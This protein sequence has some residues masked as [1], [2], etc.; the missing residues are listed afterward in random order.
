MDCKAVHESLIDYI[1]GYLEKDETIIIKEHLDTCTA[2]SMELIELK[3]TIDYIAE[4][5]NKI[6]TD[7]DI[8]LNTRINRSFKRVTRTGLIAVVLS[9][10][11]V[12]T[13][14]ATDMFGF[15]ENWK[16]SSER[17]INAW[18]QLID[19]G[20]GQK[21]DISTIDKDIKITAEGVISDEINTIILLKIEDLNGNERYVPDI[22]DEDE[23]DS[24]SLGGDILDL[25]HFIRGFPFWKYSPLYSEDENTIKLMIGTNPISKDEG[26]I[27]ININRLTQF[28]VPNAK[29]IED[30]EIIHGNWDISI[31]VK[32][33]ESK[34]YL[35]EKDID[36]DGNKLTINKVVLAPT[37]TVID[38]TIEKFNKEKDYLIGDLTFFVKS[39]SKI[40][41]RSELSYSLNGIT[42]DYGTKDGDF[43]IESL[44]LENPKDIELIVNTYNYKRR[45]FDIFNIDYENLPQTI[46]Y[47]G[48]KIVIEEM[49]E[50]DDG[51]SLIIKED[52]SRNREYYETRFY[53]NVIGPKTII[54]EGKR[55]SFKHSYTSYS[56]SIDFETRDS[57]GKKVDLSKE[58]RWKDEF[59]QYVFKYKLT[60]REESLIRMGMDEKDIKDALKPRQLYVE[61]PYYIKFPNKKTSIKLK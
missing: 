6:N 25:E 32:Q 36:L 9:L 58:D 57:K 49:I 47:K 31:P 50:E 43:H 46:V 14:F 24:I 13:A 8:K 2:C 23:G 15:L 26:N 1:D 39:G 29:N 16:K 4:K 59:Y 18:Q 60:I 21:L 10:I 33:L 54:D 11:F 7:D 19:N 30:R 40:Y 48:N 44:F 61:G 42:Y 17:P 28:Y 37:T 52:D 22:F 3:K 27:K 5:S 38:Y 34:T 56:T 12:V 41:D 45:G 55:I 53:F 35:V 51:I 20:I